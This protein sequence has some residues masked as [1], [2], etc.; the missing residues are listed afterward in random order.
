[1]TSFTAVLAPAALLPAALTPDA[2]DAQRW[3]QQ[4]LSNPAYEAARPTWFD[5]ASAA[6]FDWLN[7]LTAPTGEGL[8][9]W[10]GVIVTVLVLAALA[11]AWLIFG[12]PR[13]NRR[14]G[15]PT[16][17]FGEQDHRSADDMRR[18]GA[19]AAA[20]GDWSLASTEL[21]RALARGLFERT[22]LIVTPGTTA[23]GFAARA[24]TA[25]PSH[26]DALT[27][28]ARVFDEVRYLNGV[29]TEAGYRQML[30]LDAALRNA[31]PVSLEQVAAR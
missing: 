4:E 9:P 19:T 12:A 8:G 26:G 23:H 18:A 17:L 16:S 28:A 6:F 25:F 29:G 14:S 20:S 11:A 27:D 24:A 15:L 10:L 1:M 21:F 22:V 7:N 31:T 3:L 5:R 13:L 30:A 2:P